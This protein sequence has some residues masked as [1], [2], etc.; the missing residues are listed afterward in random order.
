MALQD[1]M[2][3]SI[4]E[5]K[6]GRTSRIR[7]LKDK[8]IS[9]DKFSYWIGKY[10]KLNGK[11]SER[12]PGIKSDFKKVELTSIP[13]DQELGKLIEFS[14]SSGIQIIKRE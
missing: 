5:W 12:R 7:S 1:E 13:Q 14:T 10:N 2:F 4:E 8:R 3:R 6:K 9:K 11:K